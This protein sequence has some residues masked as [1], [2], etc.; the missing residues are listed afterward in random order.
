ML[1]LFDIKYIGT[2]SIKAPDFT[3]VTSMKQHS[4]SDYQ[5]QV[6]LNFWATWCGPCQSEM[7][8]IQSMKNELQ[9]HTWWFYQ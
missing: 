2:C 1:Y 5:G 4:L 6:V 7:P 8:H 3:S 9:D